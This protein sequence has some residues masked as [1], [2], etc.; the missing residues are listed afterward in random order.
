MEIRERIEE[1][2]RQL[3][4]PKASLKEEAKDDRPI[5]ER[6]KTFE[7]ALNVL[8][9]EHPLVKQWWDFEAM[10]EGAEETRDNADIVAYYK[11]RV[12]TAALNEGWEPRFAEDEW[13]YYPWF[14]L[15]TREEWDALDEDEKKGGVLF[16]GYASYGANAGFVYAYS[17]FAPSAAYATFGSR[18]CFKSDALAR[19]AG[20][21]FAAL[22]ADFYLIRK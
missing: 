6:V 20:R 16:S 22:Y 12:T 13:R 10:T 1:L 11:L 17:I 3:D 7:D 5:E 15:Y 8:G 18:L 14:T 9:E 19:Y 21:Q 4:E 2:E